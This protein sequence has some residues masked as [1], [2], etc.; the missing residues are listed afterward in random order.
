MQSSKSW[1]GGSVQDTDIE[2][3]AARS[4]DN[5]TLHGD[6]ADPASYHDD[7]A[8]IGTPDMDAKGVV[9]GFNKDTGYSWVILGAVLAEYCLV[10]IGLGAIGVLYPHFVEHFRCT[11]YEAGWIGSLHMATGALIGI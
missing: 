4:H 10:A 1:N 9:A 8:K 11:M 7:N 2:M 5:E 6:T 3:V